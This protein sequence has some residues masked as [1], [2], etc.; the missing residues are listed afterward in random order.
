MLVNKYT[1]KI[2]YYTEQ[3][4]IGGIEMMMLQWIRHKPKSIHIDI[5]VNRLNDVD[6]KHKYEE[7]GCKVFISNASAKNYIK[8]MHSLNSYLSLNK[9]DIIHAHV[10]NSTDSLLLLVAKFN[11]VKVRL[12]HSHNNYPFSY[13]LKSLANILFRPLNRLISNRFL[14][15]SQPAISFIFGKTVIDSPRAIVI[16]NGIETEKFI[17]N[18]KVRKDIRYQLGID[19]DT[20][21]IG[22]VG[23]L[24]YQKDYLYLLEVL[25]SHDINLSKIKVVIVGE[26]EYREDLET[27]AKEHGIDLVLPGT[28]NEVPSY[29]CAFDLFV[30]PSRYEGLPIVSIEAQM[31]GLQCIVSCAVP[32]GAN[33]NGMLEILS[34]DDKNLWIEK[35]E[36]YIDTYKF[37]PELRLETSVKATKTDWNIS[38]TCKKLYQLYEDLL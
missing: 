10:S 12:A 38:E 6:F 4:G 32:E 19:E 15:C 2:L 17:F 16:K 31:S 28:S 25:A 24:D 8:K 22:S 13:T 27:Y 7:L 18:E 35:L 14:G 23:R 33:V 5:F 1:M 30:A 29:L 37:N 11:G 21:L 3:L 20:I 9:Y 34:K 36:Q 26:G